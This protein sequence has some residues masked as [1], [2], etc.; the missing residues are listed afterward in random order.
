M[1]EYVILIALLV[2]IALI[3][4][5]VLRTYTPK[6]K[7]TCPEG[8]SLLIKNYNYDCTDQ[9][10]TF[11]LENDGRFNLTGYFVYISNSSEIE[12]ATLNIAE[13]NTDYRGGFSPKLKDSK[14]EGIKLGVELEGPTL[15]STFKPG[16]LEE[17]NYDLTGISGN[18]HYLIIVPMRWQSENGKM[19]VVSCAEQKTVKEISCN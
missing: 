19:M 7:I 16:S 8:A 6:D 15:S 13:N 14:V 17:N 11:T 4:Y 1:L 5:A 2:V 18:A 10:L 12:S 3:V 9:K